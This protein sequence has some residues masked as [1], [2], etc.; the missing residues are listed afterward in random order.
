MNFAGTAFATS[1]LLESNSDFSV[2]VTIGGMFWQSKRRVMPK[3]TSPG[4]E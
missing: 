4:N 2:D 3:N 1:T